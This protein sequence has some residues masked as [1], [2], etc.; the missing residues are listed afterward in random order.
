MTV[1]EWNDRLNIGVEQID[2]AHK[3]LFS[4]MRRMAKLQENP[5]NFKLL[6]EEG[7]KYFKNYTMNHFSEEEAYMRSIQY[8]RYDMHK[9]LHDNL[10][11]KTLPVLEKEVLETD[12]SIDSVQH[13]MGVCMAWLIQHIMN[14]DRAITGKVPPLQTDGHS[15][16]TIETLSGA[17]IQILETTLGVHAETASEHY[18]GEPI[19][20]ITFC[21]LLYKSGE[22]TPIHAYLGFEDKLILAAVSDMM[23]APVK[24]INKMSL[25]A[26]QLLS[27]SIMQNLRQ[28]FPDAV[29]CKLEKQNLISYEIMCKTLQ[30]DCPPVS[31]LFRTQAGYFILCIQ[32]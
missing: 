2:T 5:D 19:G 4:I 15:K 30:N 26:I 31:I 18:L 6:C 20:N 24:K 10:R 3:K 8:A 1:M 17:V 25:S 27:K 9:R 22:G 7:I 16:N 21:R 11:D 14:E 32:A 28:Q 23:G 12:Y 13:F 29:D